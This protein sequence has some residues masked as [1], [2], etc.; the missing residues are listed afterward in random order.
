MKNLQIYRASAGSGKTHALSREYLKLA[1]KSPDKFNKILAVTFTNKAAEE[2]K[3]RILDELSA[4]IEKGT[5]ASH[6]Q[7]IKKHNPELSD[8]QIEKRAHLI[9]DSI[10]HNYSFFAISTIDSFVQRIIRAFAYESGIQAGYRIELDETKV[11][12]DITGW[13]YQS[14]DENKELQKWLKRFANYK[15]DLGKNW[16]FRE[17]IA[18]LSREIFKETFQK[19][20]PLTEAN[21]ETGENTER[22]IS[23]SDLYEL[24]NTLIKIK[25]S[26]ENQMN[27]ISRK[28]E[29]I[30]D[31]YAIEPSA[32]G[33]KFKIIHNYLSNKIANPSNPADYKPNKTVDKALESMEN[34]HAKSAKKNIVDTISLIYPALSELLQNAVSIYQNNF[35]EYITSSNVLSNF[36]AFGILKDMADFL[37]DYRDKNALLLISDTTLLLREILKRNEASFIYEKVGNRYDHILIDEFQDTSSFQWD[38]FKPLL[39]NSLSEGNYN[40]IVG[41]IKQSIYRW[42]GGDWKLLLQQLEQD[43]GRHQI[44][45]CF[46]DKN[47]RSKTNIIDFN[48]ALFR[49]APYILQNHFNESLARIEDAQTA[50]TLRNNHYNTMLIDA[51][52]DSY[53]HYSEKNDSKGGS[54][55]LEFVVAP[56]RIAVKKEWRSFVAEALPQTI[57]QLLDKGYAAGDIT[58]LV[59]KNK[60]GNEIVNLLLDYMKQNDTKEYKIISAESLFIASAPSVRIII[61]AMKFIY[62][63]KNYLALKNLL[64]D[65]GS[66]SQ[67]IEFYQQLHDIFALS[68]TTEKNSEAKVIDENLLNKYLPEDFVKQRVALKQLPIYELS[69]N[70]ITIFALHKEKDDLNYIRAFKDSVLH[71]TRDYG[72]DLSSFL[73]WWEQEG[74]NISV[75][76]SEKQDAVKIL[77][78]HKAKGLSLRTVI[79]PYCDWAIDHDVFAQ[80]PI[81]WCDTEGTPYSEKAEYLP[82]KYKQDLAETDFDMEYFEEKLHTYM[83]AL[84]LL[85]VTFTRAIDQLI[86]YA[87]TDKSDKITQVSD[88]LYLSTKTDPVGEA[89]HGH[90]YISLKEH[91]S[92]ENN[93]LTIPAEPDETAV[94]SEKEEP[95]NQKEDYTIGDYPV[96]DWRERISVAH[97]SSDFF[98]QSIE[99]IS[100]KVNFGSLMHQ[101]LSKIKTKDDTQHVLQ[102]IKFSGKI[103]SRQY[104]EL[105]Q[106]VKNIIENPKISHWFSDDWIVKTESALLTADGKIRIPDRVLIGES[107][108]VVIDFKFGEERD[109][110]IEQI[111]EYRELIADAGYKNINA[112]LYYAQ[113]DKIV[114]I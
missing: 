52:R 2:M 69:E 65:Y 104:A 18:N 61:N 41:D 113:M 7:E 105:E 64:H 75:Q 43:I 12:N 35:R 8:K 101:V 112:F 60:E 100:E 23:K 103:D 27:T 106:N 1:F 90:F 71:F 36:H 91:Y 25:K 48:N 70:L 49:I 92:E 28:T 96:Y 19:A 6:Y 47:W 82:V 14:I 97:H 51:Y 111:T 109:E 89:P 88:I 15:I 44:N 13:L 37:P 9:I 32:L 58:I 99:Y 62:E 66:I 81:L 78:I 46:L 40:L 67:G 26:F 53:Q 77:T 4:I 94:S 42:R 31:S 21:I 87:P 39:L 72:S 74:G 84:N 73:D 20:F 10:L 86:I 79:V 102:Q 11:I 30:I 98:M 114:E 24:F 93:E 63:P 5:Q 59:R 55:H 95:H 85:Y 34:W 57:G 68:P 80:S 38:N 3:Q 22:G 16:D 50:E 17:E 83:D 108:T 56:N 76:L 33:G 54:V 107:E 29:K 110:Y 45:E